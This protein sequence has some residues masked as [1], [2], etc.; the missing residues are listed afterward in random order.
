MAKT[1]KTGIRGAACL[2]QAA[3]K[4]FFVIGGSISG[5]QK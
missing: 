5:I 3:I 4:R 2:R 1:V